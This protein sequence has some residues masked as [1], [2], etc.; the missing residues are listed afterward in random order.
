MYRL[1]LKI[2]KVGIFLYSKFFFTVI[3]VVVDTIKRVTYWSYHLICYKKLM[4][5][6]A[7]EDPI[8]CIY[9]SKIYTFNI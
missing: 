3:V 2:N 6:Y 5:F 4:Y 7:T 9:E 8:S 1:H